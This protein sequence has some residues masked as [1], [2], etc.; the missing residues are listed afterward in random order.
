MGFEVSDDVLFEVNYSN[1][2]MRIQFDQSTR[3]VVDG[4]KTLDRLLRTKF[5][6]WRYENEFRIF[7]ELD[8]NSKEGGNYF[9]YF[10]EKVKLQEVILGMECPL[11]IAH[12]KE[13][14]AHTYGKKVHV[15]K[16]GMHRSQF[17]IIEN[18]AAR[19]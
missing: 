18:R 17:K 9:H 10:S 12:I 13:F 14:V 6:D 15:L 2:R 5:I 11:S 4:P 19:Q 3:T 7:E 16:A 8:P 1:H